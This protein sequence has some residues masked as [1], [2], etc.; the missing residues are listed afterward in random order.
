MAL[1]GLLLSINLYGLTQN[2]EPKSIVDRDFRFTNDKTL[3][4]EEALVR[5]KKGKNQKEAE[6]LTDVTDVISKAL[7][8]IHW[9]EEQDPTLYH[10]RVPVWENYFIWAMSFVTNMPEYEKYH[11]A[12]YKRSLKRGIGICGDASL[13]MSQVLDEN[14]VP[15]QMVSFPGHVILEAEILPGNKQ[16]YDPDFGVVIPYSIEQISASPHLAKEAYLQKGYSSREVMGLMRAYALPYERWDGVTHF[17]TKKYYFEKVAYMLKWPLPL[18]F[19]AF[20]A[21]LILLHK[22]RSKS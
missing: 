3:T 15:N 4:F 9:K 13:I 5:L 19:L 2:I 22:K 14:G 1:G 18:L 7:A 6:F 20:G 12:N 10:Q 21:F 17:M 16:T 8:H 11:Y